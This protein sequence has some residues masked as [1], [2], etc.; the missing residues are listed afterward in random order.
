MGTV[1]GKVEVECAKFDLIAESVR[2][3]IRRYHPAM[4]AQVQCTEDSEG[5]RKLARYIGIFGTPANVGG[6]NCDDCTSSQHSSAHC[7]DSTCSQ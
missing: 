5:F 6:D 2:Y 4:A 7:Y 1:F 3:Q